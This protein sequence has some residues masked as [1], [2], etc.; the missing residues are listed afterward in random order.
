MRFIK[1]K[2]LNSN[3]LLRWCP[4]PGCEKYVLGEKGSSK[5]TCDC[6]TEICFEC[7]NIYHGKLSCEESLD[8]SYR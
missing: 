7:N 5:I 6:G 4:S 2:I 8:S 1:L 3:P